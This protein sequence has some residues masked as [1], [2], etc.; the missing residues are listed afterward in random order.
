MSEAKLKVDECWTHFAMFRHDT[1]EPYTISRCC[2][3]TKQ[4]AEAVGDA[5]YWIIEDAK[6]EWVDVVGIGQTPEDAK[7]KAAMNGFFDLVAN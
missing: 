5:D 1:N 2:R 7:I 3:A 4:E 6:E